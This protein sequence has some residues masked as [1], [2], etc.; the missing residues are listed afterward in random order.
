MEDESQ[1]IGEGTQDDS[2]GTAK[3]RSNARARRENEKWKRRR[4][5]DD[6]EER[7]RDEE[8]PRY[9]CTARSPE[10][11]RA[12]SERSRTGGEEERT[13]GARRR[14]AVGIKDRTDRE[15]PRMRA[16]GAH[17]SYPRLDATG[18]KLWVTRSARV[19]PPFHDNNIHGATAL[20]SATSNSIDDPSITGRRRSLPD[21]L[22]FGIDFSSE[23][24][25]MGVRHYQT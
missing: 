23:S 24:L 4:T 3:K 17:A 20:R 7:R 8:R 18:R 21:N 5:G 15:T 19:R 9:R 12:I 16:C 1:R 14:E 13:R 2:G 6:E 25:Q 22:V 10:D 11:E